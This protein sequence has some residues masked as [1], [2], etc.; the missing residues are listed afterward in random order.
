MI[1]AADNRRLAMKLAGAALAMFGFGYALVPLYDYACT[2]IGLG[3][4]GELSTAE[5]ATLSADPSRRVTVEFD[6][7]V[8]SA[9]P[10][11]FVAGQRRVTVH[12][13]EIAAAGFRVVNNSG[14]AIVGQAVPSVTPAA[15]SVY[16]KKTECF[17]F[18]QQTLAPGE[19][20]D[21]PVRF[22]VDRELP[23]DITTVTLSYTFFEVPQVLVRETPG[24]PGA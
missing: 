11:Q 15:A 12:P 24:A 9:L 1:P 18:T 13:G 22:V 3:R 5:A 19:T 20:R 21:M 17:C 2:V 4:T 23:Q 8:N 7:N 14:R 6:T 16:F 10:W